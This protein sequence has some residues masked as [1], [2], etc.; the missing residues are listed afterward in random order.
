MTEKRKPGRPKGIEPPKRTISIMVGAKTLEKI[1]KDRGAI[2]RSPFILKK[3]GYG[4]S[5]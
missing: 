3:A 5:K 1:D 2:K 4:E